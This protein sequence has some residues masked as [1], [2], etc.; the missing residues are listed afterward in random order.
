MNGVFFTSLYSFVMSMVISNLSQIH[1]LILQ[2]KPLKELTFN[3]HNITAKMTSRQFQVM[4][5]VLC[6]LLL[7]R[8]PKYG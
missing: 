8:V 7:A 4:L 1:T 3:S 5:D 2:V 6:N